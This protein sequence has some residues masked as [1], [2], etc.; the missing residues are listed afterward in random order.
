[1][2]RVLG[3]HECNILGLRSSSIS[4]SE[5]TEESEPVKVHTKRTPDMEKINYCLCPSQKKS[6]SNGI[7]KIVY[8]GLNSLEGAS[9]NR[10]HLTI[11]A[12]LKVRYSYMM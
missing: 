4:V 1:M 12:Y 9:K 10:I 11:V 2:I 5:T 7:R 8:V 6:I 3:G